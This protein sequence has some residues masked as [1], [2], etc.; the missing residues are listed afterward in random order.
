MGLSYER[1]KQ[2]KTKIALYLQIRKMPSNIS[3]TL[4]FQQNNFKM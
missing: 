1:V 4:L 3:K 2:I